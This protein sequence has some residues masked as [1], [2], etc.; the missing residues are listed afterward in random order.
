MDLNRERLVSTN[1]SEV[2]EISVEVRNTSDRGHKADH[3]P[4][5]YA[6]TRHTQL[7]I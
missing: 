6:H 1:A 2:E 3:V 4:L 7:N 5:S